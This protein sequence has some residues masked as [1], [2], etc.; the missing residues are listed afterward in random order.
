M[1]KLSHHF[2]SKRYYPFSQF[3]RGRFGYRVYKLPVDAGFTCPN[4]DGKVGYGGCTYCYNPSFSP[5][6]LREEVSILDQIQLGKRKKG[7]KFL[8]YFQPFT[9]TYADVDTLKRLYDEALQDDET[10]GLCIGTRPDCISDEIL[11]LIESYAKNYHVWIEYGLQSAHDKTLRLINRCHSFSQFED[12][13]YRTQN[14]NIFICTHIILGL[15]GETRE[16]M[17]ET[18][19]ILSHLPIDGIKIHHLQ[20]I[21]NTK[22]AKDFKKGKFNTLSFDEYQS[23]VVDVLELLPQNMV[24]QRLMGDV[25]DEKILISPRWNLKKHEVLN[26]IDKE[27]IRRDTYQGAMY[28]D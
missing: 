14:R 25:L 10:V 13:V 1:V 4:R 20:V 16:D 23:L 27:L 3:L 21:E 8:V 9:N 26:L 7:G 11:L 19:S 18:A 24:I 12:A 28:E 5:P 2:G 15:P 6:T 17:L 22:M